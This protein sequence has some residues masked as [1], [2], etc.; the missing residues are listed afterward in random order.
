[1]C[2]SGFSGETLAIM[3][4]APRVLLYPRGGNLRQS[5]TY[6]LELTFVKALSGSCTPD[7]TGPGYSPKVW[8]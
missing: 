7:T 2:K 4:G 1:M 3:K 5:K 8:I 6:E